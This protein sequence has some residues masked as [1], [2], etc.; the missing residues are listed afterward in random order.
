MERVAT[1][2][3]V[4]SGLSNPSLFNPSVPVASSVNVFKELVLKDLKSLPVKK[5]HNYPIPKEGFQSLC[6]RKDIIVRPADKGEGI[7]IMDK[8]DYVAEMNRI[9]EDE[10]TYRVLP[11]NPTNVLKK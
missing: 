4:H 11:N 1:S 5:F 8:V 9:L 10:D 7:V 3:T 6:N 2:G